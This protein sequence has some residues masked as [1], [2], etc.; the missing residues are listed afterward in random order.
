MLYNG[1]DAEFD[2]E[3]NNDLVLNE[4]SKMLEILNLPNSIMQKNFLIFLKKILFVK[5]LKMMQ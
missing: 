3:L 1:F 4:I 2:I 5:F